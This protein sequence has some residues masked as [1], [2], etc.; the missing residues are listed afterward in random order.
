MPTYEYRCLACGHEF[1]VMQKIKD[2][3]LAE[4]P[5]CAGSVEKLISSGIG[6]IFKGTGGCMVQNGGGQC[7][8]DPS[9]CSKAPMCGQMPCHEN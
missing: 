3:P 8:M 7:G 4:C 1:E 5:K 2:A 9:C 6:F